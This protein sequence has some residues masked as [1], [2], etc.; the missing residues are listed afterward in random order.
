L[1]GRIL[2]VLV[3]IAGSALLALG[4]RGIIDAPMLALS[5]LT[6]ELRRG[7]S[8]DVCA[9]RTRWIWW[10]SVLAAVGGAIGIAGVAVA[11]QRRWGFLV[12]ALAATLGAVGPW[13]LKLFSLEKYP[14]ERASVVETVILIAFTLLALRGFLSG[15]RRNRATSEFP[16]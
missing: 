5:H 6:A 13:I 1:R 7:S 2:G 9:W 4:I 11:F 16:I 10:C 14:Y 12:L 15:S 3:I 8:L